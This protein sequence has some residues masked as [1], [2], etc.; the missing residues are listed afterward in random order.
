MTPSLTIYTDGLPAHAAGI[1]KLFVI[2][3]KPA[4]KNDVGLHKHELEHVKQWWAV[5][6]PAML[7]I[8]ALAHL[9][10][11]LAMLDAA[12]CTPIA[13]AFYH[14][15]YDMIPAF[16]LWCEVQAY[17]VQLRYCAKDE[18]ARFAKFIATS[19]GLKVNEAEVLE[20]LRKP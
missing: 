5:T 13:A 3:I 15:A 20:L 1:A 6:I 16:R 2:R 19:Y 14:A 8:F 9:H 18:S 12:M 7:A 4:Y 17:R 10:Y 11:G